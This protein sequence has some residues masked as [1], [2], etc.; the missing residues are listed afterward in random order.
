MESAFP[1]RLILFMISLLLLTRYWM[2]ALRSLL[3][4]LL[5]EK[6]SREIL[7]KGRRLVISYGR[8]KNH[9]WV[10][11]TFIAYAPHFYYISK[12]IFFT[13][14]LHYQGK[15]DLCYCLKNCCKESQIGEKWVVTGSWWMGQWPAGKKRSE[16]ELTF[17]SITW[18]LEKS[19][20]FNPPIHCLS[21]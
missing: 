1:F 12:S 8:D 20:H 13:F 14:T 19:M 3:I 7:E 10:G 4:S 2:Y 9:A 18:M 11:F 17:Q 21:V 15:S 5:S 6:S 16:P